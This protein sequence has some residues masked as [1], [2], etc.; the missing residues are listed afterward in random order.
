VI[1]ANGA[2]EAIGGLID[3]EVHPVDAFHLEQHMAGWTGHQRHSALPSSSAPVGEQVGHPHG[4]L[5]PM[6]SHIPVRPRRHGTTS[7]DRSPTTPRKRHPRLVGPGR[8]PVRTTSASVSQVSTDSNL[9][10]ILATMP[11]TG[12]LRNPGHKFLDG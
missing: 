9:T 3:I 11:V 12:C 4:Q 6:S 8:S 1:R 10:S 2:V 7:P 5:L